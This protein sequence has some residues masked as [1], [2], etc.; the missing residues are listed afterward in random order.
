M[1]EISLCFVLF[2]I[3]MASAVIA[4]ETPDYTSKVPKFNYPSTLQEQEEALKENPLMLR[5]AESRRQFADDPHRPYYHFVSPEN[6]LNDPNG[7]SF[8]KGKWHMF[9]QGYPPEDSRQHW[10]HAISDDL[11][12]WK[13]LPYAIYPGPERACF[14]G[15]ALV[16]DDR[17]IA[18]YH[19]TEVGN[20]V[21]VSDD[22]LL[23]NW[24]K[25]TGD[26]VIPLDN[27]SGFP[28]EYTVYDPNIWKK[29]GVYYSLSGGREVTGPGGKNIAQAYLFRSKDLKNWQYMHPFIEGDRFTLINDDYACPYFWPIGDRYILP[30]YSHMSGGQYVLGDYDKVRDK[31]VVT[32]HGNFNFGPSGP[33][34]MHAPSA[35]PHG[36]DVIVIFNMNPG[37]PTRGWNQIMS[38]PLRL[39]LLNKNQIGIEPAGDIESLRLDHKRLE[40]MQIEPNKEYVLKGINGKSMEINA[41]IDPGKSQ[42]IELNVLRSANKEEYTTIQIFPFKG[43]SQGRS[44]V[45]ERGGERVRSP[46]KPK[47]TFITLETSHS[48]ILPDAQSRAPEIAEFDLQKDENIHLRIFIDRSVVEV[49]VNGLQMVAARVYPGLDNSS[50]VSLRSQ[51]SACE[52]I[53][54]DAWQMQDI[55]SSENPLENIE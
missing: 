34:G 53:S 5:F 21:A 44:Y 43:Y 45:V 9:Y 2:S 50:G 22:P 10:A 14:S 31:F 46:K 23:L 13:D 20:M 19:G 15:S 28:F 49:F 41:V 6:R 39:S 29:D 48:S 24:E 8:W 11:I 36:E 52:L 7:L 1:K 18:M 4:Q 40:A 35:T 37:Y 16:E 54:L 30:F 38:L 25:I 12:H 26:A 33:S 55:W 47:G 51:G 27:P 17:V 42:M 3:F 32:S